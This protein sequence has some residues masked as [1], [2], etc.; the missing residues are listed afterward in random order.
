ANNVFRLLVAG[1]QLVYKSGIDGHRISYSRP[2]DGRLHSPFYTLD[3]GGVPG[4]QLGSWDFTATT[5]FGTCCAVETI[6]VLAGPTLTAGQDYFLTIVVDAST[7][8]VW[9]MDYL[10]DNGPFTFS[11]DG[12]ATWIN[13][14]SN[15]L[16]AFDIVS[17]ASG[18]PEPATMLLLGSGLLMAGLLRRKPRR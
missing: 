18:V 17:G 10:G 7:Y 16:S 9:N 2:S 8:A 3:A 14:G 1:E 5:V 15:T 11:V 4:V 12:G 6:P 13:N